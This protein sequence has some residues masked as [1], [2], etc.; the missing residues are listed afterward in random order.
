MEAFAITSKLPFIA[1][2]LLGVGWLLSTAFGNDDVDRAQEG[3]P[4]IS[5]PLIV[6]GMALCV[7]AVIWLLNLPALLQSPIFEAAGAVLNVVKWPF[8]FLS[9]LG[10]TRVLWWSFGDDS[11][12]R[13]GAAGLGDLFGMW[14]VKLVLCMIFVFAGAVF[15]QLPPDTRQALLHYRDAGTITSTLTSP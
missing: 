10:I 3:H 4:W 8:I 11:D 1:L 7:T 13:T 2:S 5:I 6:L 14:G 9:I 15:L 12:K